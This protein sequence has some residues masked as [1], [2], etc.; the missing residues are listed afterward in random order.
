M[1]AEGRLQ[2]IAVVSPFVDKR[3]GT[4]RC[5]AEQIERLAR[6]YDIHLFSSRVKDVDLCRI[7]WHRVPEIPGPHLAKY[8]FW[9]AANHISRWNARRSSGRP[10]DLVYSPGINC[11]DAAVIHIHIVFAEFFRYVRPS[12]SLARNPLR[13]WPRLI[14]RRL[15]YRL[16]MAL[17][18]RVYTRNDV[19]LVGI[20]RKTQ[21]DLERFY[22]TNGN[23][24]IAFHGI[25]V[26]R[27]NPERRLAM[28]AAAREEIGLSPEAF[29]I[30]LVGNDWKRKGLDCLWE[31]MRKLGRP[32]LRLLIRGEDDAAPYRSRWGSPGAV[33]VTLLPSREDV[34]YYYAAAD[35]L[36]APSLEDTFSLPPLEAMGAGLPVIVSRK[37]GA[38]EIVANGLDA[39]VLENPNDP[40]ELAS[41]IRKVLDNSSLRQALAEQAVVTAQRFTWD[42]NAEQLKQ[43][44]ERALASKATPESAEG[45][46]SAWRGT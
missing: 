40:D 39:L 20:S 34:E 32:E 45:R 36:V 41:L 26:S 2:R 44:F 15:Y 28:R 35:L 33:P 3:H 30:L 38:S 16:I 13:S 37:A 10:F 14:H 29:A 4:E 46:G 8:V 9:F 17:E 23:L 22:R 11:F 27:F 19:L 24:P 31:A 43:V 7:T 42:A 21:E 25:D 1:K 5:L 18:R 12:L 6:N